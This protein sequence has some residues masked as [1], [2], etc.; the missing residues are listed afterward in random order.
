M[1]RPAP[2]SGSGTAS[3]P[4]DDALLCA[5]F[6]AVRAGICVIDVDGRFVRVNPAFC[7][8][9]GFGADELISKPWTLAAPANI[10]AQAERF[11]P[12]VLADSSRI[13]DRWKIRCKDGT[14][15]DALVSFRPL[16]HQGAQF[17]VLSFSDITASQR[18]D[19]E[20]RDL[21]RD[22][23]NSLLERTEMLR[24]NRNVLLEL[25]ALDKS[26]RPLALQAILGASAR[27]MGVERVSYWR[28]AGDRS[29]I[30]CEMLYVL[31]HG[32]IDTTFAGTRLSA[33]RFPRYFAAI[34][35]N[36][37]VVAP[38]AQTDPATAEFT[39]D[40][41]APRGITSMLDAPV[42]LRGQVVGVICH[43]HIG[44]A[45]EWT[46]EEVDFSSSM[47]TMISL[48]LEAARRHELN[49]ALVRSEEKYRHVVENA[50][51]AIVI[52]QD[53]CIRYANPQTS[54]LSGYSPE[55]LHAKPFLDFVFDEDKA[56]VAA[57]YMKRMRGEPAESSYD[58]RIIDKQGTVR[59]LNINAVSL[60][61]EGRPATLNFLTDISENK[62][63]QQYLQRNLAEREALLQSALVGITFAVDRHL[64]WVNE[65]YARMLGY[66]REELIDQMSLVHFPDKASYEA[67]GASA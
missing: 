41:L 37:P 56:L 43:E 57:N 32:G 17:A 6:D 5:A 50:N 67:F 48:T 12:A 45:R 46:P 36:K 59:W 19:E 13:P 1:N 39:Q 66:R 11:L 62:A 51:E 63:L 40:Y 10:A 65:T 28:L 26:N 60:D 4:G 22:L 38:D 61:W 3:A 55:E 14:L 35:E 7:A 18:A 49:E 44:A 20:I 42:W 29:A 31:S 58:F 30:E 24:R 25:A 23:E 15:I 34:I 27:T 53:G 64:T 21:K 16:T 8:L 9:T 2:A 54:R 47:A 33:A 52:A